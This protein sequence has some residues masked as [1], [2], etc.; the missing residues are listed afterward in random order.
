MAVV[1][2]THNRPDRLARC[3]RAL[4]A[5]ER[6]PDEIIVVDDGSTP[7]VAVADDAS[8]ATVKL[9][10]ND[11]P[12]G[13]AAARNRGWRATSADYVLFTD[14]D[15]R[16]A[17]AWVA[18]ML[19]AARS[20]GILVGRT[21]PD[22]DD[23][24]EHS[25][26]DRSVRIERCD[27]GYLTC[28]VLYPRWALERTGG[29]DERFRLLG[30]D[31]DLG[32]RALQAGCNGQYV[33]EALVLHAIEHG[34][35]RDRLRERRRITDI[36]RLAATHPQLRHELWLGYFVSRDHR[37]LLAGLISGP[38][39]A[40]CVVDAL[41]ARRHPLRRA[42]SIGMAAIGA[43]PSMRYLYW[44]RRRSE[45]L[46]R[47]NELANALGW[48]ALDLVEIAFLAKGSLEHHTVLL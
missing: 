7:P 32:Q 40:A 41:S 34:S 12:L 45:H 33:P 20:D 21:L 36:A 38:L 18:S 17:Q 30:E 46:S 37:L 8:G 42:V 9:I 39:V 47:E 6:Q 5:Q 2:P 23:G 29:F 35:L 4:A 15:C 3:L 24:T 43:F 25:P 22:P 10:R 27:G 44:L 13:A 1:I 11:P 26:F 28:N 48:L 16:P 14:D 31:T 19:A